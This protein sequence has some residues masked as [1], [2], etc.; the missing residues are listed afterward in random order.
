MSVV[1]NAGKEVTRADIEDW[2]RRLLALSYE[3]LRRTDPSYAVYPTCDHIA[4]FLDAKEVMKSRFFHIFNEIKAIPKKYEDNWELFHKEK[5]E[6][7]LDTIVEKLSKIE[8]LSAEDKVDAFPH[9]GPISNIGLASAL[10]MIYGSYEKNWIEEKKEYL[11]KPTKFLID[12]RISGEGWP[13]YVFGNAEEHAHTFPTWLCMAT[14]NYIPKEIEDELTDDWQSKVKEIKSEVKEWL[15]SKVHKEGGYCSWSFRP[16]ETDDYNPVATAQAILALHFTGMV[17]K[18]NTNIRCA[19]EYIKNNKTYM[20]DGIGGD[21]K[22]LYKTEMLVKRV[23]STSRAFYPGKQTCLQ[24]MQIIALS[25]KEEMQNQN[26]L[27]EINKEIVPDFKAND[28][29]DMCSFYATLRPLLLQFP[30]A[31]PIVLLDSLASTSEFKSFISEA[32]SIILVGEIDTTYANLIPVDTPVVVFYRDN[33]DPAILEEHHWM[34][35]AFKIDSKFENINCV[36]V[37]GNRG[38][39]SSTPFCVTDRYN[40]PVHLEGE[41]VLLLIEQLKR[42]M[43]IKEIPSRPVQDSSTIKEEI[44][45]KL[46]EFP[47]HTEI[48]KPEL[49][50]MSPDELTGILEYVNLTPEYAEG[51]KLTSALGLEDRESVERKLSERRVFSRVFVNSELKGLMEKSR[52]ID[53]IDYPLVLDESSAYLILNYSGDK[54]KIIE[55]CLT[56]IVTLHVTSDIYNKIEKHLDAS[57]RGRIEEIK[58][59][60]KYIDTFKKQEKLPNYHFTKNEQIEIGFIISEGRDKK[61]IITNSWEVARVCKGNNI[62]T[63]SL[64]KFLDK[65]ENMY[66]FFR[67][68]VDELPGDRDAN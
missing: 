36:I 60:D 37:E 45:D 41:E 38:L 13:C 59:G 48:I 47:L 43:G 8:D 31:K 50:E 62:R 66:K 7:K 17:D 3:E 65:D 6:P 68:P 23:G 56:G 33:Q 19:I 24:A 39:F 4:C 11:L 58:N 51:A 52:D 30:F 2:I 28:A 26:L 40:F 53:N 12:N 18:E 25:S 49:E 44:L 15:I 32:S 10:L 54:N 5:I 57:Q 35:K 55:K 46:S 61:G 14:L 67:I 63:F 16:R 29:I 42:V 9:H 1:E 20:V 22:N 27:N 34:E 64:M 21:G